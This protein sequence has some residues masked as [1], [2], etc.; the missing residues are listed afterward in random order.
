MQIGYSEQLLHVSEW[1]D[2]PKLVRYGLREEPVKNVPWFQDGTTAQYAHAIAEMV[3][4]NRGFRTYTVTIPLRPELKL[5]FPIFFP[6]RDMYGYIKSISINYQSM[7]AATMTVTCDSL[8]RRVLVN[9][10]VNDPTGQVK[11]QYTAAPNLVLKRSFL[12]PTNVS[13]SNLNAI[14]EGAGFDISQITQAIDANQSQFNPTQLAGTVTTIQTT[15]TG[16]PLNNPPQDIAAVSDRIQSMGLFSGIAP[17]QSGTNAAQYFIQNDGKQAAG[18]V[19]GPTIKI[20]NSDNSTGYRTVQRTNPDGYYT[21]QRLVDDTYLFDLKYETVIPYTDDYGY[22]LLSPFPWG[23]WVDLNTAIQEFTENGWVRPPTDASG[24][25]VTDPQELAILKNTDA[26]LYA[27]LGTPTSQGSAASTLTQKFSQISNTIG[28]SSTGSTGSNPNT[29]V[30]DATVLVLDY[31][32]ATAGSSTNDSS[33]LTTPQPELN[34]IQNQIM[35]TTNAAQQ[36]V[37]VLISGSISPVPAAQAA[38]I[39]TQTQT[40]FNTTAIGSTP[41]QRTQ[42]ALIFAGTPAAVTTSITPTPGG[43]G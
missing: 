30:P 1:I 12:P 43:L 42:Q 6:H 15:N 9:T 14:A 28:G 27:G 10:A 37:S 35:Q 11:T 29:V 25:P 33:L 38:L 2:V 21:K 34:V 20:P 36:L 5:G 8:R 32:T 7:G 13:T 19:P 4:M 22:E 3:R 18:T 31:S 40:P 41:A 17:D 26:F 23:R 16:S 39:A 24:N